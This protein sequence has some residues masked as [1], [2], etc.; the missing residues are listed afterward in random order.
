MKKVYPSAAKCYRLAFLNI[1]FPFYNRS[2]GLLTAGLYSMLLWWVHTDFANESFL[3]AFLK[4][5]TPMPTTIAS[6]LALGCVYF[7]AGTALLKVVQG[8]LHF[9]AHMFGIHAVYALSHYFTDRVQDRALHAAINGT[10]YVLG[11]Y[12]VGST[13]MGLYL[14]VSALFGTH[15]NESYS[16]IKNEDSKS[17]V[18]MH[19]TENGDLELYVLGIEKANKKWETAPGGPNDYKEPLIR[20]VKPYDHFL[21][22]YVLLRREV[23]HSKPA[24][25]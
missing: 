24:K 12:L 3:K 21:V 22:D 7:P 2:F 20:P 11:G 1:F 5:Q 18:R 23:I 9:V 4:F 15:W 8:G 6:L 13:I 10:T 17:F 16:S 14:L 25:E 19:I